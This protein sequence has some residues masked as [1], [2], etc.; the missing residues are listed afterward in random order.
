MGLSRYIF[1]HVYQMSLPQAS[2]IYWCET[3]VLNQNEMCKWSK[4]NWYPKLHFIGCGGSFPKVEKNIPEDIIAAGKSRHEE[5]GGIASD[6]VIL[7]VDIS[8]LIASWPETIPT[9]TAK[10]ICGNRCW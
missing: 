7:E 10:A 2:V 9:E 6:I 5:E 8:T 3:W 4:F 1:L